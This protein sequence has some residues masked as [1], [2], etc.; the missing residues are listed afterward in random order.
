MTEHNISA[1]SSAVEDIA[2]RDSGE[3]SDLL[4]ELGKCITTEFHL[5]MPLLINVRRELIRGMRNRLE[6]QRAAIV[7]SLT[8]DEIE[9][10]RGVNEADL[11]DNPKAELLQ[12]LERRLGVLSMHE[13]PS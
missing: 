11:D 4:S 6:A 2:E 7:D 9:S 3:I 13:V 8:S 1:I 10:L 12:S 5:I